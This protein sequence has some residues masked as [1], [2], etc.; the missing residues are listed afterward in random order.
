MNPIDRL[1]LASLGGAWTYEAEPVS[2]DIQAVMSPHTADLLGSWVG[3]LLDGQIPLPD[4]SALLVKLPWTLRI[5]PVGVD[6]VRV[7][8]PQSEV[9][10]PGLD[11]FLEFVDIHRDGRV[12]IQAKRFGMSWTKDVRKVPAPGFRP[13]GFLSNAEAMEI[14]APWADAW[15][16]GI[17]KAAVA[18]GLTTDQADAAVATVQAVRTEFPLVPSGGRRLRKPTRR[19]AIAAGMVAAGIPMRWRALWW[20]A[21][22]FIPAPIRALI[23]AVIWVVDTYIEVA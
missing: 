17:R 23:D 13:I 18:G 5:E 10:R 15:L 2:N 6:W 12:Q 7:S 22:Y 3:A 19:Q 9:D 11:V 4:D 21:S 8:F 1:G 16:E 14:A 20:V